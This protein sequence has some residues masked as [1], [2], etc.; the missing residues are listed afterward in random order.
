MLTSNGLEAALQGG[1]KASS[2]TRFRVPAYKTT[3]AQSV[4]TQSQIDCLWRTRKLV[5][6]A[7]EGETRSSQACAMG[8]FCTPLLEDL[9]NDQ[10]V[11]KAET[12]RR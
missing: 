2:W 10:A 11:L 4:V 9:Q 12:V 3:S 6:V 5:Q 8:Q 1:R 7:T